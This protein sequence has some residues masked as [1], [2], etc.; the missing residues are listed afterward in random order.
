LLEAEHSLA[1][2]RPKGRA[3]YQVICRGE[4]WVALVLWTSPLWQFKARKPWINWERLQLLAH[5]ARFLK[6]E[7]THEPNLA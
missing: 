6:I 4:E 3:L 1:W 2:R 7:S 5:Q